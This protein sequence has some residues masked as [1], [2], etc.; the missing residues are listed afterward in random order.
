[1]YTPHLPS[2][3]NKD[4]PIIFGIRRSLI[5]TT[6]TWLEILWAIVLRVK[7]HCTTS[8]SGIPLSQ[9]GP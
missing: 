6:K 9:G 4:A 3:I 7:E 5:F 8:L 1:M 2:E